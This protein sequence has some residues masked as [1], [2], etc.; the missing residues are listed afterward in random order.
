MGLRKDR[1]GGPRGERDRRTPSTRLATASG[2]GCLGTR[3]R[4]IIALSVRV[5]PTDRQNSAPRPPRLS[6]TY[7]HFFAFQLYS[8]IRGRHEAIAG[9]W[10]TSGV[11]GRVLQSPCP[12]TSDSSARNPRQ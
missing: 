7:I 8:Y 11:Q 9:H 1:L 4:G 2:G 10:A 5:N 3:F 12:S 6:R